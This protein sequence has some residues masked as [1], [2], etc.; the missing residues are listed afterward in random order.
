MLCLFNYNILFVH[1]ST[2]VYLSLHTLFVLL[3][4]CSS[5]KRLK[6]FWPSSH[7]IQSDVR[8]IESLF[9]VDQAVDFRRSVD[10]VVNF[11]CFV[12]QIVNF[13]RFVFV[14]NPDDDVSSL[15]LHRLNQ[16]GDLQS[17]ANLIWKLD[18]RSIFCFVISKMEAS[19]LG[20]YLPNY[21]SS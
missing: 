9:Q 21:I 18:N 10:K 2:F 4:N 5:L 19:A 14:E 11:R 17:A 16:V 6:Y 8:S 15:F 13:R 7:F 1:L 12:D 3:F 20:T